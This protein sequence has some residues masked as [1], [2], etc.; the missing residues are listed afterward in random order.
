MKYSKKLSRDVNGLHSF[1][2]LI[3]CIGFLIIAGCETMTST[4]DEIRA[5]SDTEA[6]VFGSVLLTVD[7]PEKEESNWAFLKGRKASELKFSLSFSAPGFF[8][9]AYSIEVTPEQESF[10]LKK[11]PAGPY[12]IS[13]VRPSGLL[14][15]PSLHA[16]LNLNFNA[17]SSKSNYIGKLEIAFPARISSGDTIK[18]RVI[19]SENDAVEALR[20]TYPNTLENT[21]KVLAR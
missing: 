7:G 16:K 8:T 1:K 4:P 5:V 6:I 12:N 14:A 19:D 13:Q 17:R 11:L 2:W 3:F 18:Y 21:Q 20:H 10:F 9:K 15:P